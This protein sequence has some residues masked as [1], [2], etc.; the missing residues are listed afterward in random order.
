MKVWCLPTLILFLISCGPE[1]IKKEEQEVIIKLD[2]AEGFS[3]EEKHN[4]KI[5]TIKDAWLGETNS[6]QYVLYRDSLPNGYKDAVK[7]KIPIKSIACLSLTHMAFVEALGLENTILAA[8]G[9]N[10]TNSPKIKSLVQSN[11]I[12]EVGDEQSIN[13]EILVE[14]NPSIVMAYGIDES[15]LTY[16]NKLNQLGLTT[17]LNA[18][19]M[20]THPLGKAEWIKFVAAFYD[21]DDMAD[22]IFENTKQEYLSLIKLTRN[23]ENR[24]TVFVGM[25]WNG[26]WYVAGGKSFQAQLF[27]DAGGEYL[28]SDNNEKSSVI[29]SKEVVYDEAFDAMFWLNQ[30]SYTSISA[31][32]EHDDRLKNFKSIKKGSIYNNDKRI[33][34]FSGNDYWESA[35]VYPQRVLKDLIKIFHPDL[36]EHK[37]YY[38]RKME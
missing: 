34:V 19:Y 20:E 10:Y 12:A 27:K 16:I 35:T 18:E 31:I 13:Y 25:P 38:Y 9:C 15:S 30:N 22:S 23:I 7:V 5:I 24:P 26:S 14:K 28:W 4:F 2:Y 37:L 3:I 17:V 8:S 33:N 21:A 29:K 1:S 6:Q 32:I 36:I 11:K